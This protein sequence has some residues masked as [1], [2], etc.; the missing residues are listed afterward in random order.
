MII[1]YDHTAARWVVSPAASTDIHAERL[2]LDVKVK[3]RLGFLELEEKDLT[4]ELMGVR[5]G[6]AWADTVK[7]TNRAPRPGW[8][9]D[10]NM[11]DW[12]LV[13]AEMSPHWHAFRAGHLD[14]TVTT[15]NLDMDCMAVSSGSAL[16][17]RADMIMN[18]RTNRDNAHAGADRVLLRTLSVFNQTIEVTP[19]ISRPKI[20]T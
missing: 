20:L 4:L 5:N 19:I 11:R 8:I 3:G 12:V 15:D 1:R 18:G 16:N 7:V 2:V 17:C 13:H 9:N 14:V 6:G 10:P